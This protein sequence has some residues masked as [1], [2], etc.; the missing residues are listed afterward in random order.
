[1]S[2]RGFDL[3]QLRTFVA[4][5]EAGSM[6]A[7]AQ[8]VFLSQS[9]VSEQLRKLE[10][11]AGQ[12]LFLRGKLGVSATPA[13]ARLLEHARRILAMSE[14]AFEDL[15]GRTLDGELRIAITDY[16]RPH[17]VARVLKAF[18]EQHPRLRLHVTVMPSA[19]IDSGIEDDATFDI[20]LSLRIVMPGPRRTASGAIARKGTVLRREKL[21]WATSADA[22][23]P[24]A[25]PYRL[26]MLPTTCQLQRYIVRLLDESA[27]PYVLSHSASGVAGLQLALQ[28]GLGISCVNES[29]LGMGL[30][31]CAA[32]I[33][34]PPLPPVE[35]HL[36]PARLGESELVTNAR[37]AFARLLA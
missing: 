20:G 35:F 29:A 4:V 13:G 14:A 6:S 32:S 23:A 2:Q 8:R 16:Y 25:T 15:H 12:P 31:P 19:T 24:A 26:V 21:V 17:D 7:G 36:L 9:T 3:V 1:M 5:A 34:L 22:S 18:S 28:A 10:E 27:V 37:T 33:G 11:R 30:V